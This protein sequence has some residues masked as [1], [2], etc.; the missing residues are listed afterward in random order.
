MLDELKDEENED[1]DSWASTFDDDQEA[2]MNGARYDEE[3]DAYV[4]SQ[5]DTLPPRLPADLD[6]MVLNELVPIVKGEILK[7]YWQV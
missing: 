5:G 3:A 6:L 1:G 4:Q 7:W 2:I